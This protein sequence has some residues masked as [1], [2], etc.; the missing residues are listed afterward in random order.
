MI[1]IP[2]GDFWMGS[3]EGEI[4]LAFEQYQTANPRMRLWW[5]EDEIPKHRV[6]LGKFWIDEVEV[7]NSQY[8]AFLKSPE[9][10]NYAAPQTWK[11]GAIPG[12]DYEH[13]VTGINRT[14]ASAYCRSRGKRLPN[15]RQ[16]EKAARGPEGRTYPW[17]DD[18]RIKEV[19]EGRT[20]VNTL[21]SGRNH[22]VQVGSM[23]DDLSYYRVKDMG[24][25]VMEWVEDDYSPYRGYKP[26]PDALRAYDEHQGFAIA[27]GGSFDTYLHD[28]RGA[29]RRYFGSAH[30]GRDI[31]FRC[32]AD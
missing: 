24:G 10:R 11:D 22:T 8:A 17:G 6:S 18:L 19:S 27:R 29:N 32:A 4:K 1:E 12:G 9:G 21:E 20:E 23:R 3:T 16:W 7:T 14:E 5:M 31:G 30:R 15:E 28:A 26:S 25:N 13:P 2:P